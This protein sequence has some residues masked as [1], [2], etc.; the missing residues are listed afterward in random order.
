MCVSVKF[1]FHVTLNNFSLEVNK[2]FLNVDC[3]I[4]TRRLIVEKLASIALY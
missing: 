1:S 4:Y 2:V 3:W